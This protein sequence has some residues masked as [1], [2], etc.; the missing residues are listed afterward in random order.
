MSRA[1]P[2][3][4][5]DP[6]HPLLPPT[7]CPLPRSNDLTADNG[8]QSNGALWAGW[9]P[10]VTARTGTWLQER[11]VSPSPPAQCPGLAARF[12]WSSWDGMA[13]TGLERSTVG[14]WGGRVGTQETTQPPSPGASGFSLT[15]ELCFQTR[16]GPQALPTP[17]ASLLALS[18][19]RSRTRFGDCCFPTCPFHRWGNRPPEGRAPT[20]FLSP[21]PA[22]PAP[23]T[24]QG[25]VPM[26]A[27]CSGNSLC[28][29]G[30]DTPC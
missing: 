14:R 1:T 22:F 30:P 8:H 25:A 27:L 4:W 12:S 23:P 13:S 19:P 18:A 10:R 11:T 5:G 9:V 15:T 24:T 26:F 16:A 6:P 17:R 3:S 28:P 2:A 21:L 29:H 20:H 7:P